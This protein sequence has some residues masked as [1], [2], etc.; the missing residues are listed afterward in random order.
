MPII[1]PRPIFRADQ[2]IARM[3]AG[4]WKRQA[5]DI[6]ATLTRHGKLPRTR[7]RLDSWLKPMADALLPVYR[8]LAG[9]AGRRLALSLR[10]RR[11]TVRRSFTWTTKIMPTATSGAMTPGELFDVLH[12][13]VD[14]ALRRMVYHFCQ[15]ANET[16]S[17][18][19]FAEAN[20][21]RVEIGEGLR[22]G[23]ALLELT[24]RVRQ[25]FNDPLRA[26]VIARTE[27]NRAMS[28]GETLAAQ[29]SGVVKGKRWLPSPESCQLCQDMAKRGVIALDEA[30]IVDGKGPYA[31]VQ[32]PPR[33]P[34]CVCTQTFVV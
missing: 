3:L 5:A 6:I 16:V 31:E 27:G 12:P 23:E 34:N 33:H 8:D 14:E 24:A 13:R 29:E 26:Y 7:P 21:L 4:L 11:K 28:A 15:S 30:Y 10:D 17:G 32:H 19:L 22:E 9:K 2:S 18:M 1:Q 25:I 20:R